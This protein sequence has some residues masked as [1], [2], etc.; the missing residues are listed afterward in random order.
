MWLVRR[1]LFTGALLVCATAIFGRAEESIRPV[2]PKDGW[3]FVVNSDDVTIYSR[4]RAGSPIKEFK[5]VGDIDASSRVVHAVIADFENYPRFMPYTVECRLIKREADALVG[6]QRL[7][8]KICADRDYTLRVWSTSKPGSGGLVYM[9]WWTPANE[10]GPAEKP[11]VV[12][13]KI[14]EGGWLLEPQGANKTRATYSVYTDTGGLI[15]PFVANR[16][17]QMGITRLFKAVRKQVED[18]KY[19]DADQ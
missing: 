17:S 10:L 8:P 5:A 19:S 9:N 12:R 15:P 16:A 2:D 4:L 6:Y 13:V 14:C 11:G 18:P 1:L 7:S 3:K